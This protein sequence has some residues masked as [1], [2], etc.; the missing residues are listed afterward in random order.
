V[1]NAR[2]FIA[3][4]IIRRHL[5]FSGY[6]V[7]FVQNITDIEDKIINRAQREGCAPEEIAERFTKLFFESSARLGVRKADHHPRAT[8]YVGKMI[9]LVKKLEQKGFAY[10][11][12]GDVYF[13]V[14]SFA[15]Y[16]KLSGRKVEDMLSGARVELSDKKENQADFVLWKT[17]KEGEP[18]WESPWGAG[19]PG[20]H[21]ECSA[22]A[23]DLLGDSFDIHMGGTDLA[24]PHHE[25]EIAQS[26]AA[27]GKPFVK[28][29]MHNGFLNINGEKMSKSLGNFFTIDQVLA[30]F[31]PAVV[32]YFL[33][34]GHYRAPLDF[35]DAALEE[36]K[37][38]LS[39]L[40][41]TRKAALEMA[42]GAKAPEIES[43][44]AQ[45]VRQS[46]KDAMDDDFNTPRALAALFQA[47]SMI[48][49]L[50]KKSLDAQR[51]GATLGDGDRAEA[52]ALAAVLDEL[53]G[54][55]LGLDFEIPE[56]AVEDLSE[57]L[58]DLL[59]QI[60][61]AARKEKQFALADIV[62]NGLKE[63]GFDLLDRPGGAT[64]W[65]RL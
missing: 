7:V 35:S 40:R 46:Y 45:K 48:G 61:A 15:D 32:R 23:M 42:G 43:E 64:E 52:A 33:L 51:S 55:A 60:R 34:S 63:I 17:A 31:E 18:S 25:N 2:N 19:R 29:W 4:D 16:G 50:Q 39:R 49:R 3:A 5:E 56:T 53:G 20:W 27:T 14:S 1:G 59:I 6:Q 62:R 22:M 10:Q 36:A 8:Q 11:V 24:F 47:A 12:D 58:L 41:E 44:D 13:R 57:R 54:E 65:K 30:K 28:Y 9:D 38:A 26:E 37:T 21:L